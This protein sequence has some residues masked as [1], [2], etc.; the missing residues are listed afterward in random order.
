MILSHEEVLKED[1]ARETGI[2]EVSVSF[3]K[4]V[5]ISFLCVKNNTP[6]YT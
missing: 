4:N 5:I 6:I 2:D 1:A 3:L